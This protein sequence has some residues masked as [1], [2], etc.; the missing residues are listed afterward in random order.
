M[1]QRGKK[2]FISYAREDLALAR[3]LYTDLKKVGATPWLDAE[4]LLPG[5]K[6][7]NE[8]S[9][10]I[11]ESDYFLALLSSSSVSKRGYVQK[12]LREGI[13][14]FD[15]IPET[16]IYLIPARLDDCKPADQK[17]LEINW[18]DLFPVY[19]SG[20]KK[21]LRVVRPPDAVA[22]GTLNSA[23]VTDPRKLAETGWGVIFTHDANPEIREALAPLLNHRRAQA[24][25]I[26][27]DYYCEFHGSAAYRIGD[28][29]SQFLAR[30]GVGPGP[31]DPHRM[32]YY[33]LIV[34]SPEEIPFS[35]QYQ[36]G[37]Q[38]RVGRIHFETLKEYEN[39]AQSVVGVE[40]SKVQSKKESIFFGVENQ[41]DHATNLAVNRLV[42]PLVDS[43]A[44]DRNDWLVRKVPAKAATKERLGKI[45]TNDRPALLFIVA[46]GM[47]YQSGDGQQLTDQGAILCSDWPGPREWHGRI[48]SEHYFAATDVP[49]MADLRG[50]ILF[51]FGSYSAGT[52]RHG[53]FQR[54]SGGTVKQVADRS[55]ISPL[56][57]RLLGKEG[58]GALALIGHVNEVWAHSFQSASAGPQ[59]QTF[60]SSLRRLLAGD[61]VGQALEYFSHRYAELSAELEEMVM[62]Q[63]YGA[64]EQSWDTGSLQ[65][66][67]ID[68]RNYILIGDPAV[69]LDINGDD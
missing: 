33:L 34:G 51:Y 26:S 57:S 59:L 37:I 18:V 16:E 2:V 53:D 3:R 13:E 5:Q 9:K 14:I 47:G 63:S 40:T 7:K 62:M 24:A 56:A 67:A 52:T 27:E 15:Q 58:G 21:I 23:R 64:Q 61:R 44:R 35:F 43:I 36:L 45:F 60:E 11:R 66:A 22:S 28:S 8:I 31:A 32:P 29:K 50:M 12:E 42:E 46:H 4:D 1:N 48:P 55:F 25:Q 17:L 38:Y 6:W 19:E 30:F 41:D 65:I 54:L 10:A 20:L 69:R 49:E 68:A 39:Y